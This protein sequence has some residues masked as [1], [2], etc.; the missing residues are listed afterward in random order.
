MSR[1]LLDLGFKEGE[2]QTQR[3]DFCLVNNTCFLCDF[4][5]LLQLKRNVF[6]K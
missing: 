5:H 4:S 1:T 6:V 3:L 2:I